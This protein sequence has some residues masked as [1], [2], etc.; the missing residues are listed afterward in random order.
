[1]FQGFLNIWGRHF[2]RE[3]FEREYGFLRPVF[4]LR[5]LSFEKVEGQVVYQY[6]ILSFPQI[7]I[8]FIF[9]FYILFLI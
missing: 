5:R 1:M 9:L 7:F 2:E 4:T 6:E 3:H 8:D